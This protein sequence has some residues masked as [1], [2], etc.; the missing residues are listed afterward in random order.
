MSK[1]QKLALFYM[2]RS[3]KNLFDVRDLPQMSDKALLQ[4]QYAYGVIEGCRTYGFRPTPRGREW[5]RKKLK[6]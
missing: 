5:A 2:V 1:R 4:M 3:G 6:A